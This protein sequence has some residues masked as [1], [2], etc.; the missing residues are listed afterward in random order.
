MQVNIADIRKDYTLKTL[1]EAQVLKNPID[2]FGVW[3]REALHS[4]VN[5]PNAMHL[6]TIGADNLPNGRIVLLK[7]CDEE[8]FTFFT[9]YDGQ[10][11]RELEANPVAALTF[12]WPELERQVRVQGHIVKAEAAVS[13]EYFSSRPRGSQIGA[14]ASAQSTVIENREFLEARQKEMVAK[15]EGREVPRPPYWGGFILKP[16]RI[17]FWQGRASRL[18]DRIRYTLEANGDW[19]IERLSP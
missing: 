7:S 3:F 6:S 17:E 5:E 4:A 8:G 9:N 12:F 13:D 15:F 16:V 19:K 14:W 10:K 2:Q 1:D 18:H 11:G